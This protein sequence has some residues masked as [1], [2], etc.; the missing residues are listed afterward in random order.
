[1]DQNGARYSLVLLR[2][3]ESEWNK[4]NLFTGWR[5]VRLTEQ[6]ELADRYRRI[7]ATIHLFRID[8]RRE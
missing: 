1:M 4:L 2:H 7:D 8:A 3:G 6:G 5:D